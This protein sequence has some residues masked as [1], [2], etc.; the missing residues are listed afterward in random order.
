MR[1]TLSAIS[2]TKTTKIIAPSRTANHTSESK[3]KRACWL[4]PSGGETAGRAGLIWIKR[5]Q[6]E[7]Y[8][9]EKIWGPRNG[10]PDAAGFEAEAGGSK[11][12]TT[13]RWKVSH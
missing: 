4:M 13:R 9:P 3:N 1:T 11:L 7:R 6:V 12:N 2:Y 5:P 10:A 8:L